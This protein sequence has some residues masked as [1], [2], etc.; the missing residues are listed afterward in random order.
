MLQVLPASY[1]STNTSHEKN[2]SPEIYDLHTVHTVLA[3]RCSV[4]QKYA[5]GGGTD[6]GSI[7]RAG[8]RS[9]DQALRYATNEPDGAPIRH[10]NDHRPTPL[11]LLRGYSGKCRRLCGKSDLSTAVPCLRLG[12]SRGIGRIFPAPLRLVRSPRNTERIPHNLP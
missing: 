11:Q 4:R 12:N 5:D 6:G 3:R 10:R 7:P 9:G 2:P 8:T 1:L